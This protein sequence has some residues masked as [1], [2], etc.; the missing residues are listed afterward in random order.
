[1]K[2]Q[3]INELYFIRAIACMS[4]VGIHSLTMLVSH[5]TLPQTTV[6]IART[7]QMILLFATPMFILISEFILSYAY[8]DK[9]PKGFYKKR[10]MFIFLPYIMMA[11]VYSFYYNSIGSNTIKGFMDISLHNL[12]Q[13]SWHGYFIVI[14]F[15]FYFLHTFYN[16]FLSK[17]NPWLIVSFSFV[18]NVVYLYI[19][20]F[21][22]PPV[23]NLQNAEEIWY[24]Y[25]RLP[26]LGWIF[27]FS[28][29]YYGGRNIPL[30]KEKLQKYR[31][32]LMLL[33]FFAAGYVLY[34]Y[35][36]GT[37]Q[38]VSSRRIDILIYTVILYVLLFQLTSKLK[39]APNF[40]L[41]ISRY[42]F[43]IYLLHPLVQL[44]TN[45][46]LP[47]NMN[48]ILYTTIQFTMGI[49][50]SIL[51]SMLLN[52]LPIGFAFIGKLGKVPSYS[53]YKT[54]ELENAS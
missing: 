13:A 42:S 47:D 52:R 3:P 32:A 50:I 19:F 17:T 39:K 23:N 29:A 2:K 15:Q 33:V 51:L 26:F 27:Y 4:V 16:K 25:S 46:L 40:I 45:D 36:S 37:L 44:L 11:L 12:L 35:H 7:L 9:L 8:P 31:Y 5:H 28:I 18:I 14:I 54:N 10:F 48:I 21:I 38:I 22:E 53:S 1:M 24:G 43:A 6:Q 41:Q 30:F 20:S 49:V 34:N